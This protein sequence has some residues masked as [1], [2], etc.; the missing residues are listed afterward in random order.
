MIRKK[1]LN[2]HSMLVQ[3]LDTLGQAVIVSDLNGLIIHWNKHSE[4]DFGFS[5]EEAV[6]NSIDLITVESND[7]LRYNELLESLLRQ[8]TITTEVPRKRNDGSVIWVELRIT[9]LRDN[10]NEPLYLIGVSRDITEDIIKKNKLLVL[11]ALLA[12]MQEGVLISEEDGNGLNEILLVNNAFKSLA[13]LTD[14][15]FNSGPQDILQLLFPEWNWTEANSKSVSQHEAK[16][17]VKGLTRWLGLT[18]VPITDYSGKVTHRMF[19]LR[20]NSHL[21]KKE[22]QL[23]TQN[24]EL[25]SANMELDRM[26]YGVSHDLR[27]PLNSIMGLANLMKK[28]NY[29]K[30]AAPYIDRIAQSAER[31]NEFISNIIQYSKNNRKVPFVQTIDFGELFNISADLHRYTEAGQRIAF[32]YVN[33]DRITIESDKDRWQ[34]IFNNLIGNSIKFSRSIPNSYVKVM[35]TRTDSAV[36]VSVEDNGT[37]IPKDRLE[38]VFEMFYR[39]DNIRS[40]SGLGLF[41]VRETVEAIGGE[42]SVESQ[43]NSMTK[44]TISIPFKAKGTYGKESN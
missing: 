32:Q 17:E 2:E 42:I 37:G 22:D 23:Q 29:G 34:I 31:L 20:D 3:L 4:I 14:K 9:L 18:T 13:G 6:G 39:A 27:A 19:M 40:G 30:E 5:S 21:R 24:M 44:F 36:L 25:R 1:L 15:D 8:T 16:R 11:E 35:I 43:V 33:K 12:S 38:S 41:I 10:N 26:V 7:G 28:E